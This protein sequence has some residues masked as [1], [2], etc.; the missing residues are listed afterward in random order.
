MKVIMAID[1]GS[2]SGSVAVYNPVTRGC[3]MFNMPDELDDI[4]HLMRLKHLEHNGATGYLRVVM[5]N[6]GGSM[7]GNAARAARTFATHVGHLEGIF[8]TLKQPVEKVAPQTWMKFLCK[9][10]GI[11]LPKGMENKALRKLGIYSEME[12]I[13]PGGGFTKRQADAL[14]ILYWAIHN[15][16]VV[17]GTDVRSIKVVR[18]K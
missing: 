18:E 9:Q 14:G 3:V 2:S 7:P 8:A 10:R 11:E 12:K 1:P 5:E 13:F 15:P 4:V 16:E 17:P 6:V